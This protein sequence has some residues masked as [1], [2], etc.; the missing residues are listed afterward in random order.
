[1]LSL[2]TL[3]KAIV[4]TLKPL[5]INIIANEIRS[6]FENLKPAFFIQI[7]PVS[8]NTG[9]SI[10]ERVITVNIHYFS[11]EKT[12]IDNLVMIDKLNNL[13]INCIKVGDRTLTL[14]EKREELENNVLQYKFDLRFTESIKL[15]E[16]D[17]EYVSSTDP[18]DFEIKLY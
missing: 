13:F 17:N 15:E 4:D 16:D 18:K 1:M 12:E 10:Q 9:N 11:K 14:Y 7:M 3:K 5:N 2:V 6:G 8:N